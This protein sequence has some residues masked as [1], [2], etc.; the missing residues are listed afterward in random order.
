VVCSV[1]TPD[2]RIADL[3]QAATV[4]AGQWRMMRLPRFAPTDAATTTWGGTMIAIPRRCRDPQKSWQMIEALYLSPAAMEAQTRRLG[5][6][7]AVPAFWKSPTVTAPDDFFG[8]QPVLALYASLA[9]QIPNQQLTPDTVYATAALGYVL[10]QAVSAMNADVNAA[11]LRARVVD[12]LA[13]RQA[14]VERQI[15]HGR[16]AVAPR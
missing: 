9:D 1:V 14:D 16:L 11:E 5:I 13:A 15:A 6:L 8:S 7:P 3:K 10:S 2:W 12:S 4:S